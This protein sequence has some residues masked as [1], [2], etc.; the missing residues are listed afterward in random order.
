[1]AF[2]FFAYG[3]N[4]KQHQYVEQYKKTN[5]EIISLKCHYNNKKKN[6]T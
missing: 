1:M 5:S 4:R 6:Q 3:K 2:L